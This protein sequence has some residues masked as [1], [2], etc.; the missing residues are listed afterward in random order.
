MELGIDDEL[1]VS[2]P[3]THLSRMW[4]FKYW[5]WACRGNQHEDDDIDGSGVGTTPQGA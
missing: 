2:V 3:Q 4:V 5:P 1:L